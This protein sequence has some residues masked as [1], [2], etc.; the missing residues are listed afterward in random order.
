MTAAGTIATRGLALQSIDKGLPAN[1]RGG[2]AR[3]HLAG[4]DGLRAIAAL[5]VVFDHIGF[6]F[7]PGGLGV[8]AF[9]VL[10]G[11]LITW[12]LIGEEEKTSSISLPRFYLRRAFRIFPAFY[13]YFALVLSLTVATHHAINVPQAVSAGL[14]FTNYYQAIF[15]DPNTGLSHTW[16]LAVEEQFYLLWPF[17]FLL[18]GTNKRRFKMLAIAIPVLWIYREALVFVFHAPQSYIYEAFDTRADHLLVGC[19][20]AVS[21]RCGRF[22]RLWNLACSSPKMVLATLSLIVVCVA[23]KYAS[24]LSDYRDSI[25]FVVAPVLIAIL[26]VQLIAFGAHPFTAPFNWAWMRYLGL[27]SYSIY[28]YQQLLIWPVMKAFRSYPTLGVVVTVTS[29][30]VAA[31]A[32]YHFVERPF[33]RIRSRV[34][35][36]YFGVTPPWADGRSPSSWSSRRT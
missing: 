21:L 1:L 31:A 15:G 17:A 36:A 5:L 10:S 19:L 26:I 34:E 12:L 14:Y 23:M 7:V 30:V 22:Q 16:S 32:S 24:G 4:L 8:L 13:V 28:L 9:F 11:F 27:L 20:L 6:T 2:L 29:I 35:R 33:L 3:T 25:E 18:L